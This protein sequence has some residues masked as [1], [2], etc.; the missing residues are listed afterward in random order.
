MAK[1]ILVTGGIRSGKSSFA[2]KFALSLSKNPMLIATCPPIDDEIID[3]IEKHKQERNQ[4][5]WSVIEEQTDIEGA[6]KKSSDHDVVFVDC[7]T[8]W[9]NNLMH[10][11]DKIGAD[12]NEH[13]IE[14]ICEKVVDSCQKHSGTIIL[15]TNEVGMGIVP[16]NQISRKYIDLLGRCN[17]KIAGS[18]DE[19]ILMVAGIPTKI[20]G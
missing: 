15:V 17:Q 19:V 6:I 5:N 7:L 12:L 18:C 20:K 9:I 1:T 13:K 2:Q 11:A 16:G 8:L 10:E 4:D 3:R 14:I